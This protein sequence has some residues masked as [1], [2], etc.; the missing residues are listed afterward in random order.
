MVYSKKSKRNS[1]MNLKKSSKRKTR[2]NNAVRSKKANNKLVM[3]GGFHNHD[4]DVQRLKDIVGII[5]LMFNKN[6]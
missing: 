5:N 6:E 2:M 1:R 3:K 4:F